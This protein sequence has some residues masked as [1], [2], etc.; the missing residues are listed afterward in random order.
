M[1]KPVKT[2]FE[3][4]QF[5][6]NCRRGYLLAAEA[7]GELKYFYE[8]AGKTVCISFAG[9]TL[10]NIMTPA[11]EHLR[12]GASENPDVTFC[13]WDSE[14]TKVSMVNPPCEWSAFTDRGDI[15]GFNSKR[16]KT[17]FHWGDL[18]VNVMDIESKTGIYW[19]QTAKKIPYWV[20]SSPLRTLFHWWLESRGMQ[21]LHA[22]AV[23]TEN[24]AIVV[25]GKGGTGKSTTAISCLEHGLFYLSDDYVIVQSEP[26]PCVYSLYSTAKIN[27]K[28][29][30][31]FPFFSKYISPCKNEKQEKVILFLYPG[32]KNRITRRMPLKAI[33]TPSIHDSES[34][35]IA[36]VPYWTVEAAMSFTTLSQLPNVGRHTHDFICGLCNDLPSFMLKLG[37]NLSEIPVLITDFLSRL[38]EFAD[39]KKNETEQHDSL[40]LI[41]VIM[42]VYNG[43][44]FIREAIHNMLSQNYPALE[45]IVVDDGSTDDSENIIKSLPVDLRYFKKENAGP[46]SARNRG[47]TEASGEF[48][49]FLDVDDLWPENNLKLLAREM[50]SE[51]GIQVVHGYGQL[52]TKNEE[53]GNWD[54]MGNPKESFPGYIGAGL[55]RKSVFTEVGMFDTFL[56]FGEDAD[57]FNRAAEKNTRLKKL[58][59]VT[60]YVRR[61]GKNM[62]EGKSLVE[63]NVLRV[64]KKSL[65]RLREQN[66][67]IELSMDPKRV[68]VI[69]PVFN[70][71]KYLEEAIN[72]ILTQECKPLE[73][74]LIDDGSTDDSLEIAKKY[75]TKIRIFT[76][77]NKGAAAARNLGV[78]NSKGAY[79]AFL[80]ADDL[81]TPNHLSLLLKVFGDDPEL[82]MAFGNVEQ[83]ISPELAGHENI[84]IMEE[85]RIM[86]GYHPG[87]MLIKK[88]TFL[89]VGLLNEKLHLAEFVD[90]FARA[91]DIKIKQ[92]L[93]PETVYKRRIH[94]TNQ[95]VLKKEYMKDYTSVLRQAIERKKKNKQDTG[96][97][98]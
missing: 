70:A 83:F 58:E 77:E 24:G 31:N 68:S 55:Y 15:T 61:H 48:I 78:K 57:W 76:Q 42:P 44:E 23:G 82:E 72:S 19:V 18:S 64:F 65:D 3:Q 17:A 4:I 41:S 32:L 63:L 84:K 25:T 20:S 2:E 59:E 94:S 80:D 33:L 74:I 90:W 16:I 51:P 27:R 98:K 86:P 8:I 1:E 67:E 62:T 53:S 28:E 39:M 54:F 52:L 13:L 92:Q 21:L 85:N 88:E 26:E 46:A 95:G 38:S 56:N 79:L 97:G 47:I 81:W 40:P 93:I 45:I 43:A 5:F 60:L 10:V 66:P 7:A 29:S 75:K 14:S 87:A 49:A 36:P 91:N 22:A 11:L 12:A 34:S 50:F 6:S 30:G 89:K 37:R 73:I 35:E 69:I 71:G 9:E 96:T